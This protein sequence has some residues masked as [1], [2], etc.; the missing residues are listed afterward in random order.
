M[1]QPSSVQ[2]GGCRAAPINNQLP[3]KEL[4]LPIL[5][6]EAAFDSSFPSIIRGTEKRE[7]GYGTFLLKIPARALSTH[8][9]HYSEKIYQ[10]GLFLLT[11]RLRKLYD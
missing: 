10:V 11:A 3:M 7:D 4:L 8:F 9:R 2:R 1:P 5:S 6:A